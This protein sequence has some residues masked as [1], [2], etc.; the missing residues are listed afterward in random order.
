ML[1]VARIEG[2]MKTEQRDD[3]TFPLIKG[4][5]DGTKPHCRVRGH[6]HVLIGIRVI[7]DLARHL[8]RLAGQVL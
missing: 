4:R 7:A 6:A 1:A 8:P 2:G 3:V 5:L